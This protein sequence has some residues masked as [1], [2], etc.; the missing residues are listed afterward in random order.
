M[1][2]SMIGVLGASGAVG[3]AALAGLCAEGRHA[4]RAG[5]RSRPLRSDK[6]SCADW[7]P[8][9]VD[10]ETSLARFCDGCEV[11]LNAAGPSCP[12]L[13]RKSVV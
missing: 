9:D 5:Y 11:V 8:V 2:T 12:V 3:G 10:D 7:Q 4:L 1:T 13:D 6:T